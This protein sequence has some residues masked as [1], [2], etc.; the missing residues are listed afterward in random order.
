MVVEN[1]RTSTLEALRDSNKAKD[2]L[3]ADLFRDAAKQSETIEKYEEIIGRAF[4]K[5]REI[6]WQLA[7]LRK[8]L[9]A[10][11]RDHPGGDKPDTLSKAKVIRIKDFFRGRWWPFC[12][13]ADIIKIKDD[14]FSKEE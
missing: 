4:T 3:I 9:A 14:Q 2:L 1:E 7:L 8:K 6:G 12:G 10:M 5:N 13:K 11:K